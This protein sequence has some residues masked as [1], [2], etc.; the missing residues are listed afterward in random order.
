MVIDTE[1]E[2]FGA[3]GELDSVRTEFDL[4]IDESSVHKGKQM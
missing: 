3:R 1:W 2:E 4:E